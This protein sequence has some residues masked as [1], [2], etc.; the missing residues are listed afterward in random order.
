MSNLGDL[1]NGRGIHLKNR[2]W[3][4]DYISVCL[5]TFFMFLNYYY[6]LVTIPIYLIQD[7]QGNTVQAG[8]LVAVFYVAAILIRPIAGQ[9]IASYGIRKVLFASLILYP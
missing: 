9:W 3:T 2:L 6:L 8:L 5:T 7:L 1:L 4:K